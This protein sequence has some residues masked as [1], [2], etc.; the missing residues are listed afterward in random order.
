[1]GYEAE[2]REFLR[3]KEEELPQMI[4]DLERELLM[5]ARAIPTLRRIPLVEAAA[6]DF[7]LEGIFLDS[8]TAAFYTYDGYGF[9]ASSGMSWKTLCKDLLEDGLDDEAILQ[10]ARELAVKG[11]WAS[12]P[13]GEYP[14]KWE[15]A[16]GRIGDGSYGLTPNPWPVIISSGPSWYIQPDL[17][18]AA[19][20]P[21]ELDGWFYQTVPP[22]AI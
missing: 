7:G 6:E 18:P 21:E 17:D 16:F 3:A 10:A 9:P 13:E 1:M 14:P 20:E 12:A 15:V 19:V 4:L 22:I 11:E 8:P 2:Y 5:Q